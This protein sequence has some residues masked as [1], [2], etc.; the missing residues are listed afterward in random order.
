MQ[1][2]QVL[3]ALNLTEK[4]IINASCQVQFINIPFEKQEAKLREMITYILIFLSIKN[5][6]DDIMINIILKFIRENYKR[7][8]L[9]EIKLAFELNLL[10]QYSEIFQHFHLF[11]V[12]FL[13]QNINSYLKLKSDALKRFESAIPVPKQ[14]HDHIPTDE[15]EYRALVNLYSREGKFPVGWNWESVYNHMEDTGMVNETDEELKSFKEK[16]KYDVKTE[17][18]LRKFKAADSIERMKIN[19]LLNPKRLTSIYKKEYVKK[20]M[21]EMFKPKK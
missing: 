19:E 16:V 9:E 14:L 7:L 1:K 8:S 2:E 3:Q 15:E 11:D 6:P 20:K 18:E 5:E 4:K 13:T 12:S 10:G 17:T 21:A